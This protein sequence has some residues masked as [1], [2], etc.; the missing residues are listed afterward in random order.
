MVRTN[1][2]TGLVVMGGSGWSGEAA[3]LLA[4]NIQYTKEFG[5]TPT[6]VLYNLH[7]YQGRFQGVWISMRSVLR[8]TL[9][10]QTI[11]PVIWTELGQYCCNANGIAGC[12][13][14]VT[15]NDHIHG[16]WFVHNL[17][18]LGAQ[19]DISWTGWAWRGT[20]ANGGNCSKP[21]GQAEC[22]Y[23]DMRDVGGV[24]TTGA[25]G[26]A[27]WAEV[28]TTF[29]A[30]PNIV[31]QD[32]GNH[33]AINVTDIEVQGFLPRPCIVPNFGLGSACGWPLGT[34]TPDLNWVSMWN[35]SLGESVLPGLPPSGAPASCTQ[36]ACEAYECITTSPVVPMPEPCG[37][38]SVRSRFP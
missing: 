14:N 9:A 21:E 11:G 1:S 23:P 24:L 35:Q 13:G 7:P 36:Q 19:L 5:A 28:W 17:I 33:S 2:P 37:P 4:I 32:A 15:C 34:P 38:A 18:N 20:N 10:L 29:I 27:N 6:N 16:D 8:L 22:A 25:S 26:G 30:T 31:V 3:G 12:Q